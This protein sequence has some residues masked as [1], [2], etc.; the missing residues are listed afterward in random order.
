MRGEHLEPA[1]RDQYTEPP[2]ASALGGVH[3]KSAP[4][5]KWKDTERADIL[6]KINTR[7]CFSPPLLAAEIVFQC[8]QVSACPSHFPA[9]IKRSSDETKW[10]QVWSQT[11]DIIHM[12]CWH[13]LMWEKGRRWQQISA[14]EQ[15]FP[16]PCSHHPSVI[17]G[18]QNKTETNKSNFR[19]DLSCLGLSTPTKSLSSSIWIQHC[20][21]G[22]L[23][24]F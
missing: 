5:R 9:Y 15:R 6:I 7:F 21:L 23:K 13:P 20:M 17:P 12:S 2:T 8:S 14:P 3:L 1:F 22:T 10:T 24:I 4:V 19:L 11:S 18:L 16:A